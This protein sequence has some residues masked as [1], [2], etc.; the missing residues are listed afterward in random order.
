MVRTDTEL[1]TAGYSHVTGYRDIYSSFDV[2]FKDSL[3]MANVIV[4]DT[5]TNWCTVVKITTKQT[6]TLHRTER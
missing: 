1:K 4:R 6:T 2:W 5:K 3:P